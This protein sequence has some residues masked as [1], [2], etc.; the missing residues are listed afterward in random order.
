MPTKIKFPKKFPVTCHTKHVGIGSTFFA[1]KGT[2]E[3]GTAYIPLA[4]K[5]GAH[6]IVIQE[7]TQLQQELVNIIEAN[8]T[9]IE[10]VENIRLELANYSAKAT[11][12]AHKKLKIIGITGTKGKTSTAFLLEHIFKKAGYNTALVSTVHNKILEK[13]LPASLTTEPADYLHQF[14][15]VCAE[16]NVE[17]VIMEIAAQALSLHRV[18]GLAFDSVI[19]TNFSHEH[20]EFYSSLENYFQAKCK[21]F[22][23]LKFDTTDAP[24]FINADDT[25]G[26]RILQK[27]PKFLSF[28]TTN[29]SDLQ[30]KI[31]EAKETLCFELVS[32]TNN[33][34]QY[35]VTCPALFGAFNSYNV[36]SA[37]GVAHAHGIPIQDCAT[38]IQTFS[39]IP[40][41]LELH[42]LANGARCFIDYAHN[43]SSYEA[44]LPALREMTDDL[45]VIFGCGGERDHKKRP[46]MGHIATVI[47][48]KII[49][50]SDNP[51][52]EDPQNIIQNITT[53]ITKE[54]A[55]KVTQEL[56]RYNAITHACKS[57]KKS[58]VI[59]ILGKG[60]DEYQIIGENKS[61]FSEKE[62]LKEFKKAS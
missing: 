59:A 40:G 1:I 28:G 6:K 27:H 62:I 13:V 36:T 45:T 41:R 53:G 23:Q 58:S 60:P 38:Y 47:A 50:T 30:A 34:K 14:F 16:N 19:F 9:T 46:I 57:S 32:R 43:P 39:G 5:R 3:D 29:N 11:N 55:H 35:L 20:G 21:I 42:T 12:H 51:R 31:I 8:G 18:S 48:D 7:D 37:I 33:H 26:K 44:I 61:F 22:D 17:Y 56:D 15:K 2:K 54:N 25:W 10:I 49:L 24:V 4:L 52:S